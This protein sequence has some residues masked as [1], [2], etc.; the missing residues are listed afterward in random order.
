MY[1]IYGKPD[2]VYCTRAVALL[3][4][5]ELPFVYHNVMQDVAQRTVMLERLGDVRTLPQIFL[6][7]KHVGGF[8]ELNQSLLE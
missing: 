4:E 7:D 1:T 6:E 2:C 8:T 5:K 3:T